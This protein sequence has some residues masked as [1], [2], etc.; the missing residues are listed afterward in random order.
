MRIGPHLKIHLIGMLHMNKTRIVLLSGFLG[1]G[2]TTLLKHLL[3]QEDQQHVAVV[4]NE[5]GEV[6]IDG[7]LLSPDTHLSEITDGCICCTGRDE[8]ERAILTLYQQ[9]KPDVIYIESSGIAHPLEVID[10][11]LSPVIAEHM[12]IQKVIT[13]VDSERW[14]KKHLYRKPLQK[15]MDEQI[16][17]A[18]QVLI[19]KADLI[20]QQ[21]FETI[22][23]D[24]K[25]IQPN[26]QWRMTTH[27]RMPLDTH[28]FTHANGRATEAHMKHHLHVHHFVYTFKKVISKRALDAFVRALPATVFRIK[29][30]VSV[31]E[32]PEKTTLFQYSFGVP[33]YFP[34]EV[35]FP[36]TLV[37][38]GE[39]LEI[40]QLKQQLEAT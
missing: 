17:Y 5:V 27:G 40:E 35:K 20:T 4:M 7:K 14:S 15:L 1:S 8:L 10:A 32:Y 24:I 11:C 31:D 2:K 28:Y 18:D 16:K 9:Q 33:L 39:D 3:A 13:V 6:S 29:G 34:Q 21:Q 12:T 26:A 23:Q 38:I 30:F 25:M 36:T 19:N 37:F 22:V